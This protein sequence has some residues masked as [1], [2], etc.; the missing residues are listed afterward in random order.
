MTGDMGLCHG[1]MLHSK[2]TEMLDGTS[3]GVSAPYT[4]AAGRALIARWALA[5]F[6][7]YCEL[8]WDPV[9][10]CMRID[11]SASE[12]WAFDRDSDMPS[13]MWKTYAIVTGKLE[14]Y[15]Q[16][17]NGR[18]MYPSIRN[19]RV[20]HSIATWLAQTALLHEGVLEVSGLSQEMVSHM[21]SQMIEAARQRLR[22]ALVGSM[23]GGAAAEAE[24]LA[25]RHVEKL[26]PSKF[27][28]HTLDVW[29]YAEQ[30]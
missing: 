5:Y 11:T 3:H 26:D 20:L 10:Q 28:P 24:E 15:V 6:A 30:S 23:R 9:G 2:I 1:R 12:S 13:D 22:D 16:A 8:G 19:E 17:R 14:R 25:Y 29:A 4:Y 21:R 7:G 18:K 27:L